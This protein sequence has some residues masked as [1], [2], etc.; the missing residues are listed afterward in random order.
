MRRPPDPWPA[1][2]ELGLVAPPRMS[3][4]AVGLP[5]RPWGEGSEVAMERLAGGGDLSERG[6][7]VG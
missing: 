4:G 7:G 3:V 5:R 2:V 1:P 6:L